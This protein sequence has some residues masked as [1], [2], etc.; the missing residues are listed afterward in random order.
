MIHG[1]GTDLINIRH[2][3]QLY[4]EN[5]EDI[6]FRKTF[7]DRERAL[8][9]TRQSPLYSYATRFAGKEAVF[10]ALRVHGNSVRLN[11]IEI[12]EDDNGAPTVTLHGAAL[13]AARQNGISYIHISLSYDMDYAIAYAICEGN[14]SSESCAQTV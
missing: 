4:L 14:S 7:T 13:T 2:I 1:I 12:L 5:S 6:F 3:Q 10:K 11:E 9:R 8:I